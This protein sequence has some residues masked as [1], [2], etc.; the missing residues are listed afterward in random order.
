VAAQKSFDPSGIFQE[1]GCD[2]LETLEL[3]VP[4]FEMGLVLVRGED[5]GVGESRVVGDEREAAVALGIEGDELGVDLPAEFE[6]GS[7][8]LAVAVSSPGRPRRC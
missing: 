6:T 1:D 3:G 2:E 4:S 8:R 7:T 5:L